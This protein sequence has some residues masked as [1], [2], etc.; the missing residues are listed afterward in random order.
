MLADAPYR[1]EWWTADPDAPTGPVEPLAVQTDPQADD[2]R[3]YTALPWY[4]GPAAD[5]RPHLT[6]PYV[7]YLCTDE[8]TLT[9]T[10][11]VLAGG[12]FVGVVGADLYVR[13]LEALVQPVLAGLARP[14]TLLGAT[15]R[16]VTSSAG[17]VTGDLLR[18]VDP[19]ALLRC[20]TVPLAVLLD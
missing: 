6:G 20:S 13:T 4:A 15:G 5:H 2:F 11:P 7:D 8:Y 19:G 1:L 14:A 18:D 17:W 10:R 12:R 3:D 9:F 16:V